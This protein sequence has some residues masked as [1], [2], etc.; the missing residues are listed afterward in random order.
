MKTTTVY[1]FFLLLPFSTL[2]GQTPET[3]KSKKN[4]L[5][6]QVIPVLDQGYILFKM[7]SLETPNF[8]ELSYF[9]K[10][11]QLI[12]K[13]KIP[14]KR[15]YELFAIEDAFIWDNT[16]V[17]LTAIYH[18]GPQRNFLCY[19]Q[20]N[21]SDLTLKKSEILLETTAPS[22]VYVPYFAKLSSD[23]NKLLVVGWNYQ[24][25]D[26]SA[27]LHCKV[28]E[29]D[30]QLKREEK[31]LTAYQNK[32]I[33]IEDIFVSNEEIVYLTGNNHEGL[34]DYAPSPSKLTHFV[35]G[36]VPEKQTQSWTIE[37][38]K[39][40]FSGFKY[41]L[42]ENNTLVGTSFWMKGRKDGTGWVKITPATQQAE[43][44]TSI[45][46][47]SYL[48]R[49][50]VSVGENK[51]IRKLRINLADYQPKK[52]INKK[53]GFYFIGERNILSTSTL[54]EIFVA[55]FDKTGERIWIKLIP[56]EQWTYFFGNND[57]V[58]SFKMMERK[59][60]LY[61]LFNQ[62]QKKPT[63]ITNLESSLSDF[64]EQNLMVAELS[65]SEETFKIRS[66]GRVI[67]EHFIFNPRLSQII[68]K[69]DALFVGKGVEDKE[70]ELLFKLVK[71]RE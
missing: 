33:A 63:I 25:P 42:A 24:K 7:D 4:L 60:K 16:L 45:F 30:L 31:I 19:Y 58:I 62:N 61:F 26:D 50:V 3:S 47:I 56:K 38:E 70:G 34:I 6:D 32:R 64:Y 52:L 48:N 27:Q 15:E 68:G 20:Y 53:E 39:H 36:T 22:D 37:K 40:H 14:T 11:N 8:I 18:S 51:T 57:D 55:K 2:F 41:V 66:I 71:I 59:N 69:E 21:L 23:K 65:L 12:S 35:I 49:N 46:D 28:F 13:K 17:L 44:Q 67:D 1:L 54:N 10:N 5:L 9:N 29:R 43:V